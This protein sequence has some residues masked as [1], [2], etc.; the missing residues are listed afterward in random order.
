MSTWP[1]TRFASIDL[2]TIGDDTSIN[3]DSN[4]L[5]YTVEDGRLKIGTHHHRQALLCRHPLQP[6][7][8]TQ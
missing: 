7:A 2:L 4:L 5:G 1:R 8:R 6:C 3:A